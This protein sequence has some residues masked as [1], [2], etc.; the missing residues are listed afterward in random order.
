MS[1]FSIMNT[2]YVCVKRS[3]QNCMIV[4]QVHYLWQEFASNFKRF[5]I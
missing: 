2:Q 3:Y 4:D 1:G 5:N